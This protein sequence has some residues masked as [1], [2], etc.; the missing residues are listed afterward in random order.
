MAAN[1]LNSARAIEVSVL[2]VRAFVR[3]RQLV[4]SHTELSR[5]LDEM[6]RKYDGQFKVVFDAI[7][8]LMEPE[9]R[10]SRRIGFA[11]S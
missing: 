1:V 3:M 5:R 8:A 2:V 10:P 7:R 11:R 4:I 9:V 6:E